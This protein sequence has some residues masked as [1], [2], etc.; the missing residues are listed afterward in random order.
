MNA[1]IAGSPAAAAAAAA[2]PK[3][4]AAAAAAAASKA[5]V[6][7]GAEPVPVSSAPVE[8]YDGR[9]DTR[10][11]LPSPRTSAHSGLR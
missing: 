8:K 7:G 3:P 5:A 2:A 10:V 6:G 11:R 9:T 4:T 1:V